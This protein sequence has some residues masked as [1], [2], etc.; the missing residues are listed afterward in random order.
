MK[1]WP[2]DVVLDKPFALADAQLVIA[3]EYGFQ[4]WSELK[5]RV[6]RSREIER[7]EPHPAFDAAL[8]AL[9]AGDLDRLRAL[10]AA[11]PSLVHARTNLDPP[12]GYFSGAT[13]L[14]H[15][16]GNPYRPNPLPPNIVDIARVLLDGGADVHA[17]TLG[18]NGGDT[19]GLLVTG[20]QASDMGVT[21][22]LMDLLLERGAHLDLTRD[23]ALD[24]SLANHS[25]RAAEKMIELGAKADVLAAAALG[26]MDL[27]RGFFNRDGRLLAR[28]RRH[29]KDMPE[30]DAIGLAL[31]YAY[32]RGHREAVDF[33]LEK[34][35]NWN[36]IGVN[37][38]TALHRAAW[39]GDLAMVERLVSKGADISN[40][41]NPFNS[42]PLSWAQ[43]NKQQVVFD[44]FRAHC[45]IDLHDAVCFDFREH[46]EA[47]LNEDPASVNRQIDQWELPQCAPLHWAAWLRIEDVDGLH[48]RDETSRGELVRLLLEKGA[49]PNI[50]AGNGLTALD[51]ADACGATHIAALLERHGGKRST[52][53][54]TPSAHPELKRFEKLAADVVLASRSD[55]HSALGRIQEFLRRRVTFQD[56][57]AGVRSRLQKDGPFA[58]GISIA[59][60]RDV[61]AG[62]RGFASWV[63]LAYSVTRGDGRATTWAL[64]LYTID[65]QHNRIDVRHGLEDN[66]WNAIIDEIAK[67]RITGLHAA[68]QMTDAATERL[69]TLDHLTH[70]DVSNSTR[71]TDAGL[72]RI[73]RLPQLR[74]L[75][76]SNCAITDHGLEVLRELPSLTSFALNWDRN[77]SDAGVE[78]LRYCNR[79]EDVH[80]IGSRTGDATIRALAG[81]ANLRRVTTGML[82]TD[83]GLPLFHGFPA[84]KTWSGV[85]PKYSLMS[86]RDESNNLLLDGPFTNAGLKSLAG[87]AGLSGLGFF[88]HATAITPDGM[89]ALMELPTLEFI[90]CGGELCTDVAMRHIAAIPRLR[91]LQGQGSVATD[92]GFEALSR[93]QTIEYIWGRECPNLTGRGFMA[94]AK[95]P[96]LKGLGVSCR[97]VDDTSLAALARFPTLRELMPMDVS[98][99]GFR[100]V[101]RC[102]HLERLWCMYC[103]DT[104]DAATRNI[105]GLSKLKMYY[106]GQTRITDRSLEILGRMASLESLE[107]WNCA[108]ITNAG[109]RLL[110]A[111]PQLRE[112]TFDRCRLIT[113]EV[114][115]LF[116]A[117]VR[118]RH[119]G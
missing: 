17:R 89:A 41:D 90:A 62:M 29:G 55:D 44:W 8:D 84:F 18:P 71:L 87:L 100:H 28:P 73:A 94:L 108:G 19:M 117:H 48:S 64:P 85:R 42:T 81:K 34:D 53:A 26:R 67:K 35:G 103:R 52:E 65:E 69:V 110:A 104:T 13:L 20:K 111:L 80:L 60:A 21:G 9:D 72:R 50:V 22:P 45:A 59:E 6:E 14:H 46:I 101:G 2:A 1:G 77:L 3:R 58:G 32:V 7:L 56:I 33:L 116:P 70:L 24:A 49:D 86:F 83:A 54:A 25:P 91:M 23:D 43:H 57:R 40:R 76:V 95:M 75:D 79:I 15:V 105:A 36:V 4:N 107:F 39:Q 51:M 113:A 74:H 93:S 114:K 66:D 5:R 98:D 11:D 115:A 112:V 118:V 88:W 16:A 78:N 96:A 109:A 10:I 82:M 12:Y 102:E 47:R 31:L 61:V 68:G 97:N 27:L 38:G 37:N 99:A 63:D 106:A 119:R 30:R 92:S